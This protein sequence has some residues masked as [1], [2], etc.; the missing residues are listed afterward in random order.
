MLA[1]GGSCLGSTQSP[2][3]PLFLIRSQIVVICTLC[4]KS[5]C[6]SIVYYC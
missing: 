5:I 4:I 3:R 1:P 2:S 6:F